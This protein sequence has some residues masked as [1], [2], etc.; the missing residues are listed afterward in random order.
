MPPPEP[1]SLIELFLL[2]LATLFQ[3]WVLLGNEFIL[4][5]PTDIRQRYE[6]RYEQ[7]KTDSRGSRQVPGHAH[8]WYAHG[9]ARPS[10]TPPA[11]RT[12]PESH[13]PLAGCTRAA[14]TPVAGARATARSRRTR[15]WR[16][17]VDEQALSAQAR[18]WTPQPIGAGGGGQLRD[19]RRQDAHSGVELMGGK[20]PPQYAPNGSTTNAT[21]KCSGSCCLLRAVCSLSNARL[22]LSV[23][24]RAQHLAAND[25]LSG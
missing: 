20:H 21:C 4:A 11:F 3:D 8:V 12:Q 22:A 10:Y 18:V 16:A 9:R 14:C 1:S 13:S 17:P 5:Y 7:N 23:T 15:L 19:G 24:A 6:T 2:V 25:T